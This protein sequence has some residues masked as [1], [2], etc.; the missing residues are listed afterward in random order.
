MTTL[1]ELD[2]SSMLE[3]VADKASLQLAQRVVQAEVAFHES[4]LVQLKQLNEVIGKRV[5]Q[6]K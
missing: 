3:L 4:R 1:R 2:L 5:E 6:M